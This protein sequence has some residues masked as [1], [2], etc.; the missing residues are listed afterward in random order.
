LIASRREDIFERRT[1]GLTTWKGSDFEG[2][3]GTVPSQLYHL[4]LLD[5]RGCVNGWVI[6][7][8]RDSSGEESKNGGVRDKHDERA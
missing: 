3:V 7:L 4:A 5:A 2:R 6:L 8:S 1:T